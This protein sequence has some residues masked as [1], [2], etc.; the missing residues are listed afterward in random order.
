M[1]VLMDETAPGLRNQP[2]GPNQQSDAAA[3]ARAKPGQMRCG[4]VANFAVSGFPI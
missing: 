4:S 3:I 2:L 1:R